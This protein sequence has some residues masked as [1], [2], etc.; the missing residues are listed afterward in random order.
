[1]TEVEK[2]LSSSRKPSAGEKQSLSW[3]SVLAVHSKRKLW[4]HMFGIDLYLEQ[5]METESRMSGLVENHYEIVAFKN[6]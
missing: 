6:Y 3:T 1:M 5:T 4:N 2:A